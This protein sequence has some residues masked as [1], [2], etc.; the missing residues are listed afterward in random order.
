MSN[1]IEYTD[2]KISRKEREKNNRHKA[3]VL[4][5]TGLS[6]S[7]KST[8]ASLIEKRLFEE[9]NIS[10]YI[11][12]GDSLRTGLNKDLGFSME[13]RAENIR[14]ASEVAKLLFDA[15]VVVL[16]SFISPSRKIRKEARNLFP[17][18]RFVETYVE[19]PLDECEKRDVKGLYT[20]A[21]KG[22]IKDFTGIDSPYEEPSKAEITINTDSCNPEEGV[23]KIIKYLETHNLLTEASIT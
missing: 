17:A 3:F 12:D 10:T 9:Y 5:F 4:W 1:I 23:R 8:L 16:S 18:D 14:R 19:C 20:K 13:D 2:F 11:L 15:G 22:E 21:R 7:G 6:G